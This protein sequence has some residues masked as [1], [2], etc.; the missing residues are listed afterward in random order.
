M[1]LNMNTTVTA[2][3]N[4]ELNRALEG[5]LKVVTITVTMKTNGQILIRVCISGSHEKK[6]CFYGVVERKIKCFKIVCI[7]FPSCSGYITSVY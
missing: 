3:V 6:Q 5:V 2:M 1:I 7:T 4:M